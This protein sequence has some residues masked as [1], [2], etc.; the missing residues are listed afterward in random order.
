[1]RASRRSESIPFAAVLV[2]AA[3]AGACAT[4]KPSGYPV[5]FERLTDGRHVE[6]FWSDA[7]AIAAQPFADVVLARIDTSRGIADQDGLPRDRGADWLRSALVLGGSDT[8]VVIGPSGETARV[9]LAIT[10]MST[11]SAVTRVLVGE[12]GAG[13]A[14]VQ[15]EGR[16]VGPASDRVLA[17]FVDRRRSS[18]A[19]G[20]RD[21]FGD[22]GP[23]LVR[24]MLEEI[25]KDLRLE[26]RETFA[27]QAASAG[28]GCPS[29]RLCPRRV[30]AKNA[31]N[32]KSKAD[33]PA[34]SAGIASV[35]TDGV[36][37]VLCSWAAPLSVL[38]VL[39][40]QRM[41]DHDERE[42]L[43]AARRSGRPD[44]RGAEE[45]LRTALPGR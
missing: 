17:E 19:A 11:G 44:D 25:A 15:V 14:W 9:E 7:G 45:P 37:G 23:Q 13:H 28:G 2:V 34:C 32:A 21:S 24:E 30:A 40:G 3:L 6:K 5:R 8:I 10:E 12:L 33:H 20:L 38:S 35:L 22:A 1:M 39:C 31:K 26:L 36:G 4:A 18:G 27:P 43:R 41:S 16:V 42:P 29:P